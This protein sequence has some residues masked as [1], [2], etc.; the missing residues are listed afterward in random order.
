LNTLHV[1]ASNSSQTQDV[2]AR[3]PS[4]LSVLT[5]AHL[6]RDTTCVH[7]GCAGDGVVFTARYGDLSSATKLVF[8][9]RP[10]TVEYRPYRPGPDK[11]LRRPKECRMRLSTC[12]KG[13]DVSGSYY[14]SIRMIT[15][16]RKHAHTHVYRRLAKQ[17]I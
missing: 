5:H 14:K 9:V 16:A 6:T 2:F 4:T 7:V 17:C 11:A 3:R 10:A 15:R 8:I 1:T 13:C 12:G